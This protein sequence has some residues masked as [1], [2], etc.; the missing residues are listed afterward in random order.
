MGNK[1]NLIFT[2]A[3]S[4]SGPRTYFTLL[5]KNNLQTHPNQEEYLNEIDE[6]LKVLLLTKDKIVIAASHLTSNEALR[7][8]EGKEQLFEEGI[9]IPALRS[10]Y[11]TFEEMYNSKYGDFNKEIPHFFEQTIKEVIPWDLQENSGWF[12]DRIKEEIE[13]S[14]S[15]LRKHI[16]AKGCESPILRLIEKHIISSDKEDKY[17]SREK[18]T[19]EINASFSSDVVMEINQW[20]DLLYYI[21]GSRVVNCENLVPQENLIT[22]NLAT[23]SHG[24]HILSET[25]IF[26]S[27]VIMLVLHS[28]YSH[29]YP[30]NVIRNL[31]INDIL[32]LR[33]ENAARSAAFRKKYEECLSVCEKGRIAN[34]KG[35]LVKSL[36]ELR[37][38][39][40]SVRSSFSDNFNKE[41]A[42]YQAFEGTKHVT[43]KVFDLFINFIGI[44]FLPVSI[45]N[46]IFNNCQLKEINSFVE[47]RKKY[48]KYYYAAIR[49]FINKH[50]KND[51]LLL[52]YIEDIIKIHKQNYLV[53][54]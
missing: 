12:Y 44:F 39:A 37:A 30:V 3:E 14:E 52:E 4:L 23:M 25:D 41:M 31:S 16:R 20:I 42:S 29:A 15:V 24:H 48:G 49:T 27:I 43:K 18:L 9:I 11:R 6:V 35:L 21:S 36:S 13:N 2:D 26:H 10:E 45:I 38:I 34:D 40:D 19:E 33:N 32:Q 7:F 47:A 46:F 28:F 54:K 53:R 22:F 1:T 17:F 8:F 51:P 50:Y 5:D